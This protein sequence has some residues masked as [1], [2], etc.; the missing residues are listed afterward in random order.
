MK[1]KNGN[2][3]NNSS[4]LIESCA[5]KLIHIGKIHCESK[6]LF[7]SCYEPKIS[8]NIINKQNLK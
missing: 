8:S 4:S 2:S 6:S 7:W 1:G 5:N 3:K